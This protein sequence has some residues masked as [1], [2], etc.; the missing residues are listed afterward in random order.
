MP[1]QSAGLLFYRFN[2]KILEVLLVHPGGPFWTKKDGGAWSIPKGEIEEGEDPLATAIREVEEE[3]GIK[4]EGNFIELTPVKQKSGK[5]VFAWAIEDDFDS[6][7]VTSNTFELEW[8]P[9]SGRQKSFPEIDKAEWFSIDQAE[10]KILE[11]QLPII[12]ELT[13]ILK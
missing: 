1:K 6:S 5:I 9:N 3:T 7:C 13:R 11:T 10:R 2:T 4:P 12:E 8:P